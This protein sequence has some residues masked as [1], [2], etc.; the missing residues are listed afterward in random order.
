MDHAIRR[1]HPVP[2]RALGALGPG[3]GRPRHRFGRLEPGHAGQRRLVWPRILRGCGLQLANLDR[4]LRDDLAEGRLLSPHGRD[5]AIP[6]GQYIALRKDDPNQVVAGGV[7]QIE[8]GASIRLSGR[9]RNP[10][11]HI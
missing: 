7:I 5:L 2:S 1:L 8:H 11:P 6:D 3:L 10:S 4:E 9:Q